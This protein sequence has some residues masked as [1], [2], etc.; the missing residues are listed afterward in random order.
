MSGSLEW[1]SLEELPNLPTG[2]KQQLPWGSSITCYKSFLTLRGVT[3]TIAISI[4]GRASRRAIGMVPTGWGTC[5]TLPGHITFTC[6]TRKDLI[7]CGVTNYETCIYMWILCKISSGTTTISVFITDMS[8]LDSE[9]IT[10]TIRNMES[11][12]SVMYVMQ[13]KNYEFLFQYKNNFN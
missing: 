9:G 13:A 4:T 5:T 12:W 1:Q 7:S 8:R 10:T 2:N 3:W 11:S 6:T